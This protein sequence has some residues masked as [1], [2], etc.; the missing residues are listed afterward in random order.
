MKFA[1]KAFVLTLLMLTL[2]FTA[3][4]QK[5][6]KPASDPRNT[7]PTVG[8]GGSYGGPTGLFTV[9]DGSTLRR[10]EYTLSGAFSNYDRDPGNVDITT[11]PLSFQVGLSDNVELFFETEGYR[12]VKVNS[13]RNLS[14]SY[15]QNT[16]FVTT[17]GLQVLPAI[18][19]APQ[20]PGTSAFPGRAVFR[21]QGAPWVQFP[22][23]GGNAGTYGLNAPFFSG[24]VFGFGA[25]TN[26]QLGPPRA[27]GN[28]ADNFPGIG[29][30]YGSILPG[31][32]LATV[33]LTNNAGAALGTAPSVFSL[34]PTYIADAPFMSRAYGESAW[35]NQTV[36]I[37]WRFNNVM[38]PVSYGVVLAYRWY[39]DN[40]D[41]FAGY[42][43]MQRGAGPGGNRGD[44]Q[45]T[46][47]AD[48]RLAKWAN[49]SANIGFMYAADAKGSFPGGTFTLLDR[50]NEVQAAI[51]MDF[52]V[53]K[54]FQPIVEFRTTQYVGGRTPNALEQ[55]PMDLLGGARIFI[56]RWVGFS[57]AY[58]M[59]L[60]P[61][62][63]NSF[64]NSTS[65]TSN[66][67]VP[68]SPGNTACQPV[69]LATNFTGVPN[70]FLP[71]TDPHGYMFQFF[72]GRRNKRATELVNKPADVTGLNISDT[73]I[74]LGCAP[75]YKSRSGSCND[76]RT[77][78]VSTSAS[79]PENDPLTYNYTVSGGRIVGSGANVSWDLSGAG[80]GT[81]TI[82]S[83]VDDGCGV[84]GKTETKTVTV[85][86][87]KD[88]EKICD[89][90][91]GPT[92]DGP[93][94]LIN[95]GSSATF[96]ANVSG[97]GTFNW[98]VSNGTISSGQGTSSIT[99]DTTRAM[100][101]QS[102][103]ATVEWRGNE[104][105]GCSGSASATAEIATVPTH[106][107]VDEF[108]PQKDDEVKARVD[109]F[110]IRLN[111]DP[112]AKGYIINYGTAAQ[113]KARRA[114]ILR[115]I[116]R[117]GAG[118]DPSRVMFVDSITGGPVNTK[119]YVVPAGADNPNP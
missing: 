95:A 13:R 46:A 45:V 37:K 91:A 49:L 84:C 14:G 31:I 74:T 108:G 30:V 54:F 103:T 98:S 19:M 90:P 110:Y 44:I 104:A 118:H 42:N 81:Y 99:V 107:L 68:C 55:N 51:G 21:P 73:T 77:V 24:P 87:C 33:P 32:V 119:F 38:S 4:A 7:A 12:A 116:N 97:G 88:C 106:E 76:S 62:D 5:N 115:A 58:R 25:G 79:D 78:S 22:F 66:V 70:G 113:I 53:N 67:L 64:D 52:P 39:G 69:T 18:V 105:C 61:Q 27:G 16:Q 28:G 57:V 102:I 86:E 60:N 89:C 23:S 59:N 1:N 82:T 101:G 96:T 2:V 50:P 11:M 93:S 3:V 71:S 20:G 17:G 112:T 100:A 80:K 15:A 63:R 8:T 114:Q 83:A 65:F 9:Y 34:A 75:G 36:G 48:S 117:P 111:N 94:G 10:G 92:V 29:S 47:F 40:A 41:D 85:D 26:A 35:S 109:N 6:L 56:R 72:V 43:Q